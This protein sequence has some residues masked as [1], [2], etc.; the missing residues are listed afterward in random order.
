MN[1][2]IIKAVLLGAAGL[3]Y[4]FLDFWVILVGAISLLLWRVPIVLKQMRSEEAH[5]SPPPQ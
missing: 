3:A 1:T 4:Y 2:F 5:K